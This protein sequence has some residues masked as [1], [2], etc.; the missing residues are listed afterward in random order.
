MLAPGSRLG[1]YE[2]VAPLGAG[3]MGEVYRARDPRLG[4]D[5][6]IKVIPP[7]TTAD[8]DRRRR[9][10][11]EAR[12]VAAL[13]H[14]N[15]LAI[16]D[17]GTGSVPFLVTELLEG[18]TLRAVVGRGP[19][20]VARV[21]ELA[22]QIVAGLSAAHARGIVHRDLKPENVFV[23]EEGRAKILDFGLARQATPST[24]SEYSITRPQTGPGT[25]MGTMG[26]MAPEQLRG[27]EV[28]QRADIFACGAIMF[29]M[30]TGR[31]AF[32]AET[33]ADA[34]SAVLT[35]APSALS[36]PPGTPP[37][38]IR[39]VRRCL[40]KS[41]GD[42]FQSARDLAFAIESMSDVRVVPVEEPERRD[43]T[44]VAVL[45]FTT[46]GSERNDE[47]HYFSEGLSEELINAL[48]RI[49]GL[50][51]ASPTSSFRF[52]GRDQDIRQ[53]GRDLGVSA[54]LE[55]SVRRAGPRLRVTAQLTN[56]ADGYHIWSDRY[57]REMAD[58]FD[59]QDEIVAS[60]VSALAPALAGE[61]QRAVRRATDNL[62]AYELY[63]KGRHFW[64]QRSPAVMDAA[65]RCFEEAIAR[66]PEYALAYAGLADCYS[67]L[68]VYGW[69]APEQARPRA[70]EAVTKALALMPDLPEALF[71]KA[72]YIFHFEPH[73]RAA[74]EYFLKAIAATRQT[75]ATAMFEAYFALFLA[76][77]Y[78]LDEARRRV[79][80]ALELDPHSP[81][82]HFL[83]AAAYCLILD[84][85]RAERHAGRALEMLP[86]SMGARWPQTIALLFGGR[87][88]E[89]LA[90]G[91][92]VVAY[93]RAPI[94]VG[95]LGMVY[96]SVGRLADAR[97]VGQELEA[98]AAAGEYV[99][100]AARLSVELALKNADGIRATLAEC[101]NGGAA[102]F[103]VIATSRVLID[104]YRS[105]PTIAEL[106]DRLYDG[107]HPASR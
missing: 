100:P 84:F 40:E 77:E 23:T 87:T 50:R 14:P 10:E 5:V 66:D 106:V 1:P 18:E 35:Q 30:L 8:D 34:I 107:A 38:L 102:P 91:E 3:G 89:A 4:R 13:S 25:V 99:V 78:Q 20:L 51:V 60:I 104:G 98:R 96:A 97:R 24:G 41:A 94:Y 69:T 7:S 88:D 67:I 48:T 90:V 92:R 26:Y 45:P 81:V 80:R 37:G 11:L 47:H 74:R 9:F 15:V 42:R 44:S 31:R 55:G 85:P 86:E 105:D 83:A 33:P 64:N 58:V 71:S 82:I 63:L 76:S 28:D 59:I 12:A 72:L 2:I 61:A 73:W 75:A 56:T 21:I 16:F 65:I 17:I 49:S 46:L 79:A 53:I 68:R 6:A 27:F 95:V 70:L 62:E 39:I 57:D 52:R 103:S 32:Q 54:I 101:V 22:Q 19:L 43:V 29:E 93:A 36:F